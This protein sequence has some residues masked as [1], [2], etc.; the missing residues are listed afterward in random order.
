MLKWDKSH[1]YF[2]QQYLT[3]TFPHPYNWNHPQWRSASS[4]SRPALGRLHILDSPPY[5]HP[6]IGS[7]Q[8]AALYPAS[9]KLEII[10]IV[11]QSHLT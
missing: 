3:R 9:E 1:D 11:E 2:E 6:H 8:V 7:V 4:V 10:K 5:P